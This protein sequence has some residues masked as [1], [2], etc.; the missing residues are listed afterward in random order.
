M[1]TIEVN[2]PSRVA[3]SLALLESLS[4]ARGFALLQFLLEREAPSFVDLSILTGWDADVLSHQLE[5]FCQTRIV[6]CRQHSDRGEYYEVNRPYWRQV[7]QVVRELA[8]LY[9]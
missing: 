9:H 7:A 5:L 6:Q 2:T 8:A 1:N 3:Q 4:S